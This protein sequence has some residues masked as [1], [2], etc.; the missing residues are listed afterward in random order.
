MPAVSSLAAYFGFGRQPEPKPVYS[1]TVSPAV[2]SKSTHDFDI[3]GDFVIIS[4]NT[5]Y[6]ADNTTIAVTPNRN[7]TVGL[8]LWGAGGGGITNVNGFGGPGGVVMGYATLLAGT[9]YKFHVG[10]A[11]SK[12]NISTAAG[13][14]GAA[15][16]L[17]T[18]SNSSP[19]AVAGGGG[20]SAIYSGND[21]QA[22]LISGLGGGITSI[23]NWQ[24]AGNPSSTEGKDGLPISSSATA[25][26]KGGISSIGYGGGDGGVNDSS[27]GILVLGAGGGGGGFPSGGDAGSA[28]T[29]SGFQYSYGGAGGMNYSNIANVKTYNNRI[30]W[31]S[32]NNVYSFFI[33]DKYPPKLNHSKS[34]TSLLQNISAT[35]TAGNANVGGM[36]RLWLYENTRSYFETDISVPN[37]YKIVSNGETPNGA[38]Y[39]QVQFLDNS[40]FTIVN[41]KPTDTIEVISVGAGG[42]GNN[43][44]YLNSYGGSGAEAG[45]IVYSIIPAIAGT[46]VVNI[47][48]NGVNFTANQKS[49]YIQAPNGN[50][51]AFANGGTDRTASATLADGRSFA[52]NKLRNLFGNFGEEDIAKIRVGVGGRR[53]VIYSQ[54]GTVS[55][56]YSAFESSSSAS[57]DNGEPNTGGGGGGGLD[58]TTGK[59]MPPGYDRGIGG[60][61][62]VL[63]RYCTES[64]GIGTEYIPKGSV[65][66]DIETR[67]T[68][69]VRHDLYAN[70]NL[71]SPFNQKSFLI[72]FWCYRPGFGDWVMHENY[73]NSNQ[74]MTKRI[75]FVSPT[76]TGTGNRIAFTSSILNRSTSGIIS[77]IDIPRQTWFHFS[78]SY[79]GATTTRMYINGVDRTATGTNLTSPTDW[80]QKDSGDEPYRVILAYSFTGYI[81]NFIYEVGNYKTA[82]FVPS[83]D[84]PQA[85]PNAIMIMCHDSESAYTNLG[86]SSTTIVVDDALPSNRHSLN[87]IIQSESS[88]Y[89]R[90]KRSALVV[91]NTPESLNS[92]NF[93]LEF[94]VRPVAAPVANN[95]TILSI[96]TNNPSNSEIRVF[97]NLNNL[98]WGYL[99][100]AN[101]QSGSPR[102]FTFGQLEL[103]VWHH[104][105]LVRSG[106]DL[107]FYHNGTRIHSIADAGFTVTTGIVRIGHAYS[108]SSSFNG[109]LNNLRIVKNTVLYS[110]PSLSVPN[111]TLELVANTILL[112]SSTDPLTNLVNSTTAT[113]SGDASISRFGPMTSTLY[114]NYG[115]SIYF[116]GENFYYSTANLAAADLSSSSP[117]T[118]EA[119]IFREDSNITRGIVSAQAPSASTGWSIYVHSSNTLYM[120][121]LITSD[122]Y[123]ERQLNPTVIPTGTWVHIAIVKDATGYTGYVNGVAGTKILKSG[124]LNYQ[125]SVN[126]VAG[127]SNSGGANI[128][129]GYIAHIRIR[130]GVAAYTAAFT[131]PKVP[132]TESASVEVITIS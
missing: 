94:F 63:V 119:W 2:N 38:D 39:N 67:G 14:G 104:I 88:M 49:S 37:R 128:F 75:H 24:G 132:L 115:S 109:Y 29:N 43:N 125:S 65:F 45:S 103:N 70:N 6:N 50:R 7:M 130:K 55:T 42:N 34:Y 83:L 23:V 120:S 15:T 61:G 107:F 121:S 56:Y 52:V 72:E 27:S 62:T 9:S 18:T 4:G 74:Y 33:Y 66:F 76:G 126:L 59:L 86:N 28:T 92:D 102:V 51:Y 71:G 118:I 93:T 77:S 90:N 16:V 30:G 32:D 46:Y 78:V 100:P 44:D 60:S 111:Q 11:G 20:G 57:G 25:I 22:Y 53:S 91:F 95:T 99:I 116:S 80:P 36:A 73:L 114:R 64:S 85:N 117:F 84:I 5:A 41:P 106:L 122:V 19:M 69:T 127:A 21:I 31:I 35:A 10:T 105:A 101:S 131:A 17:Y 97:Q 3:D 58:Y 47:G 129:L 96:G 123:A 13:G 113:L 124:G 26:A 87:S 82:G 54:T 8:G 112:T 89:F 12:G 40:S 110:D 48:K 108:D 68:I 1:L 81:S 79:D 98:G